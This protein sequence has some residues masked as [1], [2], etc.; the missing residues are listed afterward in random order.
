METSNESLNQNVHAIWKYLNL[1]VLLVYY[2]LHIL[3]VHTIFPSDAVMLEIHKLFSNMYALY[4][5]LSYE[6]VVFQIVCN[7]FKQM[8]YQKRIHFLIISSD[9]PTFIYLPA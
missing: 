7:V 9:H 5:I 3:Y 2:Q 4:V 6:W 1:I 8:K